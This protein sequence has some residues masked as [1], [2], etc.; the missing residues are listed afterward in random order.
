MFNF[1]AAW[2]IIFGRKSSSLLTK[3]IKC[4]S[5]SISMLIKPLYLLFISCIIFC[6]FPKSSCSL[7]GSEL[8][9]EYETLASD[10]MMFKKPVSTSPPVHKPAL[11]D[12]IVPLESDLYTPCGILDIISASTL[13]ALILSLSCIFMPECP[14][15][16]PWT[17]I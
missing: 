5:I 11:I 17:F 10:A 16:P 14:P 7:S 3:G 6:I 9:K 4:G 12:V 2:T 1:C 8:L 13:I 15:L